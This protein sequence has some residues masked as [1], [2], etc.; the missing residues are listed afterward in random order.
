[1]WNASYFWWRE[2]I[3]EYYF[4]PEFAGTY[5]YPPVTTYMMYDPLIRA[6]GKFSTIQVR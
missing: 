4:K 2:A 3:F 1:M 5:T 6:N